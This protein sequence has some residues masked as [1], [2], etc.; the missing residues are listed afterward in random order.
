MQS[1]CA[2]YV[3][4]NNE[5]KLIGRLYLTSDGGATGLIPGTDLK[6]VIEFHVNEQLYRHDEGT[7]EGISESIAVEVEKER[8]DHVKDESRSVVNEDHLSP[9]TVA[10]EG[11][12]HQSHEHHQLC[13]HHHQSQEH[14]QSNEY[15]QSSEHHLFNEPHQSHENHQS[16]EHQMLN[17]SQ[18]SKD[19]FSHELHFS[20]EAAHYSVE[21]SVGEN[22]SN[23]VMPEQNDSSYQLPASSE[24]TFLHQPRI[25]SSVEDNFEVSFDE[26]TTA[27]DS[28][29]DIKFEA[30]IQN[31]AMSLQGFAV[32]TKDFMGLSVVFC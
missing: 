21:P 9:I 19:N 20:N 16:N 24:I 11:Q 2:K 29:L 18:Y 23:F 26:N 7:V 5:V 28:S 22:D 6:Y 32:I 15:H 31:T 30:N 25:S 14:D 10:D 8:Q 1:L 27:A 13:E 4:F 17:E 12:H 3:V